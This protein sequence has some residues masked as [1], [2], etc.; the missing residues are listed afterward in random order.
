MTKAYERMFY[1]RKYFTD[2][3]KTY[4]GEYTVNVG[5]D[6]MNR[7]E[8]HAW[9][10]E[11]GNYGDDWVSMWR[12]NHQYTQVQFKNEQMAFLFR[13]TFINSENYKDFSN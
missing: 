1:R 10:K 5:S 12:N 3:Q 9:L 2:W 7:H 6:V 4:Y 11:N 13:M 8:L